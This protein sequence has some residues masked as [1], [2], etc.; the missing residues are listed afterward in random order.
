[1][2]LRTSDIQVV[3]VWVGFMGT[4]SFPRKRS[5]ALF[6]GF[7]SEGMSF[8]NCTCRSKGET[9]QLGVLLPTISQYDSGWLGV[10][11]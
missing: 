10:T 8:L 5:K 9:H 4:H 7:F 11:L 1:M 3:D 2:Y 6:G